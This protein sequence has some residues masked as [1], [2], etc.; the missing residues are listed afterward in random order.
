MVYVEF[1]AHISATF[2]S[3]NT[4]RRRQS[5][6]L[7]NSAR[8][9]TALTHFRD[10][11]LSKH[12]SAPPITAP[13]QLSAIKYS[14]YTFRRPSS[15]RTQLSDANHSAYST[16]RHQ[17]QR[18]HISATFISANTTRRRQSQRL[19]NSARSNTA[20]THFGDL[21]LSEHNSP[22]HTFVRRFRALPCFLFLYIFLFPKCE[23]IDDEQ[24]SAPATLHEFER[25]YRE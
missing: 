22:S 13:I 25:H 14:A 2:I 7:F 20:L 18:L 9:N 15:Q 6:R 23:S 8:S 11:H 3:A 19:F 17:I 21:H 5:Q 10:L 16:R 1:S 12:N 4:T 24:I